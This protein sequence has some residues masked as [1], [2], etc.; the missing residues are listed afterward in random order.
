MGGSRGGDADHLVTESS[1]IGFWE[2]YQ[3]TVGFDPAPVR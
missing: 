3:R 2:Y 1:I